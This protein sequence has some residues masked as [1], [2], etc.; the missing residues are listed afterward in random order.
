MDV[1]TE[2]VRISNPPKFDLLLAG[3]V[4]AITQ[5]ANTKLWSGRE[6]IVF[7][8]DIARECAKA[9]NGE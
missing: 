2:T 7:A 4:R 9:L 5:N 8:A 3:A 1:Q 6:Q